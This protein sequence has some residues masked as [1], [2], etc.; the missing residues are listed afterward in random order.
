M[1]SDETWSN[2]PGVS[3]PE[4]T[5]PYH[6]TLTCQEGSI[7]FTV[8]GRQVLLQKGDILDLPP[9]TRHSALVGPEGVTCSEIHS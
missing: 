2:G 4:H 6:K 5:H 1:K 3:Y 7:T 9:N 8:R